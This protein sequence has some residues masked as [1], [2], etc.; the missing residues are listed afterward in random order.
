MAF[1]QLMR[2]AIEWITAPGRFPNGVYVVFANMFEF[3]DGTGDTST[4]PAAELSGLGAPWDDPTALQEMMIY[5]NEQYMDIA[6]STG[7]DMIFMLEEF[8]GHGHARN[9]PAAP[10]YRGPGQDRWFDDTCIHPNPMGH[11]E[12]SAMFQAVIEE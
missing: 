8:C 6:V 7:T 1:V 12:I 3:T 2:E 5:A 10:C 9:D 4:C 11:A